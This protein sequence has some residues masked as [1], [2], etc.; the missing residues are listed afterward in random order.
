MPNSLVRLLVAVVTA[1]LCAAALPAMASAAISD[2]IIV[3]RE[4]GLTAG[5]RADVRS[6]AGVRFER[7]LPLGDVELVSAAPGD[8]ADALTDLRADP[9]VLWAEPNRERRAAARDPWFASEWGLENTG[10]DVRGTSGTIDAD[11][12]A[13]AAWTRTRGR[14]V[15]VGVVDSGAQLDHPDL[16]LVAGWDFVDGDATPSDGN[17]HGTHVAGTIAAPENGIGATGVAPAARVMP[18]RALDDSGI[19]STAT[20][21]AAFAYAGDHGVRIVNASLGSTTFSVAEHD[22]IA[23]HPNTLYVVAAGN[24]GADGVGDDNDA[25]PTYPCAYD[26][27]NIVCVGA[28]DASDHRAGFSNYGATT[29]DLFAPGVTILSTYID[30]LYAWSDGTSMAAPHAAGVAALLAARDPSGT[31]AQIKTDLLEGVDHIAGLAGRAVTGGRL[32]AAGALAGITDTTAPATPASVTATG[33]ASQ[34][35]LTWQTSTAEDIAGYR[36]Y[37]VDADGTTRPAPI[38]LPTAATWV[39]TG[40]ADG[41]QVR[42][43]VSAVDADGNESA[44]SAVATATTTAAAMPVAATPVVATPVVATPGPGGAATTPTGLDGLPDDESAPT[45]DGARV[46]D[47][48]VV[49]ARGCKRR[50]ATLRF[51]LGADTLVKVTAARRVCTKG[52]CSYQA[53]GTRSLHL[54]AGPHRLSIASSL[55]GIKLRTGTWRVTLATSAD[56]TTAAFTVRAR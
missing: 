26:L 38:A 32:N 12:D 34:V 5:E 16:S 36:V 50:S 49:C 54:G 40:L 22:A 10:Q 52:R 18:L 3:K 35:R 25:S 41:A 44:K 15:T 37:A 56:T 27:E 4:A 14:G 30:G 6:D 47:H 1:A 33:G 13:T 17:G 23:A 20:T 53:A 7:T 39:A 8:R 11:I 28:T 2:E 29:V 19:G 43:R 46:S 48:A 55:A 31:V 42:L 45:V 21:A 9:D 51:S 24:G